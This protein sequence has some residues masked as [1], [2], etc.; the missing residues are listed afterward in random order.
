[1][2]IKRGARLI[3]IG[4]GLGTTGLYFARRGAISLGIDISLEAAETTFQSGGYAAAIQA[5]AETLP[6]A[7]LSF[8]G[9][10][11]MGTLEHFVHP[12]KALRETSRVLKPETQICLV[13]PNDDFFLFRFMGGTG[14]PHEEPRAYAGWCQLFEKEGWRV[15][16]VYRD[17][18]PDIFEGGLLRGILRK[19]VLVVFNLLPI[20]HTYQ[21]VFICRRL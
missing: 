20:R 11:F 12:A 7:D 4:C 16:M 10:A 5:N 18:G 3:D 17:I 13:V 2:Y 14:Q 19:L 1:M 9:A 15:E 6:F 8:D 21:F